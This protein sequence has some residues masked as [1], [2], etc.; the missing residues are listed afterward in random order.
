MGQV[1]LFIFMQ[2]SWQHL[3]NIKGI[4]FVKNVTIHAWYIGG[5]WFADLQLPI[6]AEAN[7][8]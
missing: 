6:D 3:Y 1:Y 4:D 5:E 7:L 2:V 8:S